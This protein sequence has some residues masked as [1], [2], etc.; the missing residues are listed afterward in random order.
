MKKIAIAI[1]LNILLSILLVKNAACQTAPDSLLQTD[2]NRIIDSTIAVFYQ[3]LSFTELEKNKY[4]DLPNLFTVQGFLI[5]TA[6]SK[7]VFWTVQQYAQVAEENFKKQKMEVW[8][9]QETCSQTQFFGKV[10]QRFST[11]KILY[12]ADGKET[13]RSGINAIQLIKEEDKWR[14]A[15]LAWDRA[16][17]ALP[18]PPAYNC[19]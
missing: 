15:N 9:E 12:I 10:A 2:E 6:G 18:I 14:I 19:N 3:T 5:S 1:T 8:G 13:I 16:S 7:P 17:D 4:G 11:Y